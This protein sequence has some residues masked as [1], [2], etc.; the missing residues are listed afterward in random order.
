[1]LPNLVVIGAPKAGTTSLHEYLALH[2]EIFMSTPKEL[3]FFT[4]KNWRSRIDEYSR[5]FAA[6]PIRGESSPNYSLYPFGPSVAERMRELI[7]D[8]RV[9]YLVREP[10][11][12]AIAHYVEAVALRFEN[13]PVGEALGDRANPANPYICGSSYGMQ[14]ERFY[15]QF[16]PDRVL[17][18]DQTDLLTRRAPTLRRVFS[19]LGVDPDFRSPRFELLHNTR[20]GKVKYNRLG[21]WLIRRS[22]LS[23][24]RSKLGGGA[25]SLPLMHRLLSTEIDAELAAGPRDSLIAHLSPDIE[26][27]RELTGSPFAHWPAFR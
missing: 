26:R 8:A 10:I 1:M 3:K 19:F 16:S 18:L 22:I 9:I 27:L 14:I 7:P 4:A 2:P 21:Y 17:V 6:A 15:R 12:R 25:P 20:A 24:P 23:H 13:R 5:R 11:E